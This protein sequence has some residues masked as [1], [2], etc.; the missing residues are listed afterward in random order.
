MCDRSAPFGYPSLDQIGLPLLLTGLALLCW[1]SGSVFE[2]LIWARNDLESG[3]WWRLWSGHLL[4]SNNAHLLMNLGG[5]ILIFALHQPHYRFLPM[6]LLS[7]AMMA[8]ISLGILY[9]VPG[10]SR[11]VGLSALLHGLFTWGALMDIRVGWRSGYLMLVGVL[12][13]VGWELVSGG[14]ED[15]AALIDARVAVE[16]HALGVASALALFLPYWGW[17]SLRHKA[18]RAQPLIQSD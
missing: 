4:H 16:S 5:L 17:L 10:I 1:A 3:Q 15:T 8:L 12:V 6:L 7:I 9:W 18:G 14:S 2:H 13:K 11:Y